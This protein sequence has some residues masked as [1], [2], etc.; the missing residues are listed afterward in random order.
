M[1]ETKQ[2][3]KDN[4]FYLENRRAMISLGPLSSNAY[5]TFHCA[6]CYV[7][8][9]F[10]S[11]A[12][13]SDDEIITFL[14]DNRQEYD[15]IYVSGDTDSFA[16]PRT[17][18]ALGLLY[19]I[20]KEINCDLLFTTRT[21]FTDSNYEKIKPIVETQKKNNKMLYACVSITRFSEDYAYLEPNPIPS[22]IKRIDVL[23]KL[24][25]LCVTTVLAIRPFLPNVNVNDYL[26]II[27]NAKL[28]I[29]IVLGESFYFVRGD[30]IEKRIFPNGIQPEYEI[31]I[32]N[33]QKMLFDNNN[34]DWSIWKATEYSRQVEAKC[35][36]YNIIFAMHS[37]EAIE[38]YLKKAKR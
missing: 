19:R 32:I 33:N 10:I 3:N 29:D 7:Q 5:C 11:Y 31:D 8:D 26:T 9:R 6:F 14:K 37:D 22:P 36:E 4:P 27:D 2:R 20:V 1:C 17:D 30:K 13:L 25:E 24:K 18:R 12:S 38:K 21:T 16:P 23:K 28:Y 15:I 34:A 35:K